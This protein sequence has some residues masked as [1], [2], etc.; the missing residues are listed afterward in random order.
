MV[1]YEVGLRLY[2]GACHM[3]GKL[4]EGYNVQIANGMIPIQPEFV[5]C[6][7]EVRE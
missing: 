1:T 5:V 7:G 3:V 2:I 6:G 4:V